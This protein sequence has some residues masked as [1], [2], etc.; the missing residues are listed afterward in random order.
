MIKGI[1]LNKNFVV[2]FFLA[3]FLLGVASAGALTDRIY[4]I[5][6]LDALLPRTNSERT[7]FQQK[8]LNEE[9]VVVDVAERVS[10]S[11]VT[12]SVETPQ[13]RILQLDPFFGGFRS[14]IEG[15]QEQD[16]GSGF[17]V[18]EEGLVVTNKHVVADS[19]VDYK[20][21]TKSGSEYRVLEISR[22]PSNDVA[23]LKIDPSQNT[24]KLS[25]VELGDSDSLKVGQFVIAIGT[26]LGEFRHTVTTGVVSGLGRGITAGSAF[27]GFVER[28]DDVIQTDAAI[29][30]GNSGGPLLNSLGQVI[31]INVAV[32]ASA[33][34][35]GFAIPVNIVKIGLDQY[36]ANGRFASKPFLGVQYQMI[37]KR[38]AILNEVPEG[39]YV[40]EIV[41]GSPAE[42]AGIKASDI[43]T[44]I[45]GNKLSDKN[46]LVDIIAGKKPGDRVEIEIWR[47]EEELTLN[48]T[49]SEFIK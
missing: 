21:I 9:N 12:V 26:A 38:S 47:D 28:I 18:S 46:D 36:K 49:L 8:I 30:P 42:N 34:N 5:K 29:N 14:R 48:A 17:V 23:I 37:A 16:I 10:P 2:G 45:D 11:V 20:V 35:V 19:S 3:L 24:E 4:G 22:D 32:A 31:G 43:I 33:E 25:S 39:A 1:R 15:G 27:E 41:Q 44:K 13:R 6:V 7:N 40:V